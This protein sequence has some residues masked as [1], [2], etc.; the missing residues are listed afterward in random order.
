MAQEMPSC[1]ANAGLWATLREE[2]RPPG[3]YLVLNTGAV[4]A[5]LA[6]ISLQEGP[7]DGLLSRKPWK[8]MISGASTEPRSSN[9]AFC[10]WFQR[11]KYHSSGITLILCFLHPSLSRTSHCL[12]ILSD[13]NPALWLLDLPSCL[14]TH[15]CFIQHIFLPG[16]FH[17]WPIPPFCP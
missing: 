1:C 8:A 3:S 5:G 10:T 6:S 11:T 14:S 16:T 12:L 15:Y 4:C 13:I 17:A 7:Q 2:G 9:W